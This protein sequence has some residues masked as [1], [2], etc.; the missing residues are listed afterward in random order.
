MF[1]VSLSP[2]NMTTILIAIGAYVVAV[3]LFVIAI[4]LSATGNPEP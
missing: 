2:P 4:C 3:I 1:P